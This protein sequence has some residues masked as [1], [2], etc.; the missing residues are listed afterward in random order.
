MLALA[1]TELPTVDGWAYEPKLDGFRASLTVSRAGKVRLRSRRHRPLTRYFP[2]IVEAAGVLPP[3][4]VLDGELVVPRNGGVDFAALQLRI[5][6]AEKR[7]AQLAR[8]LPVALVASA[9]W[10]WA[11]KTCSA[12]S[13]TTDGPG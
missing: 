5:H 9:S 2:E 6:P 3:G 13:T 4:V 1:V 12:R 7:V 10:N 8:E 11:G